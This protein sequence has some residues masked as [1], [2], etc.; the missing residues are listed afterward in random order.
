M[1]DKCKALI[2][3]NFCKRNQERYMVRKSGVEVLTASQKASQ[4]RKA[5]WMMNDF[6]ILGG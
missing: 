1:K 6:F 4:F 3:V 5:L 2:W